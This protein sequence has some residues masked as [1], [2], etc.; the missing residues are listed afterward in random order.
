MTALGVQIPHCAECARRCAIRDLV[1]A[2]ARYVERHNECDEAV[3]APLWR[4]MTSANDRVAEL[5]KVY[6]L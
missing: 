4:A 2:V 6:P 1:V 5:F 3:R